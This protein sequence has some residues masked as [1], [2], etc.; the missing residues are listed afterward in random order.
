MF[1]SV[2]IILHEIEAS[3]KPT[4]IVFNKTDKYLDE[5]QMIKDKSDI[6]YVDNS[7]ETL[8]KNLRK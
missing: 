2:N 3:E 4:I 1:E 8:I 6:N 5:Q 7:L